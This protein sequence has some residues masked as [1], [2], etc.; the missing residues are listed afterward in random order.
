[1]IAVQPVTA[2]FPAPSGATVSE[3]DGV[4]LISV[5]GWITMYDVTMTVNAETKRFLCRAPLAELF[6]WR[7]A[8]GLAGSQISVEKVYEH[9][10]AEG[11]LRE[12]WANGG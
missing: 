2:Q 12:C 8:V 9:P 5:P 3:R 11:W 1:M 7:R 10:E 6:A 4:M